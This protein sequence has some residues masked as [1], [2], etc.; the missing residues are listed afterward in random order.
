ML[1]ALDRVWERTRPGLQDPAAVD[2]AMQRL[3]EAADAEDVPAVGGAAAAL[4]QA[5]AGLHIR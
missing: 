1:A 4:N 2:A 5:V 3:R